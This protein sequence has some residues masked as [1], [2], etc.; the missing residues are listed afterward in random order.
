MKATLEASLR[1]VP[2]L[3]EGQGL[4]PELSQDV[5]LPDPTS[6]AENTCCNLHIHMVCILIGCTEQSKDFSI[7]V[8]SVTNQ[9]DI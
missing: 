8:V 5:R 3:V 7:S 9:N 1:D 6:K 2:L 4:Y